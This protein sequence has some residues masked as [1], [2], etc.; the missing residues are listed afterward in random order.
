M[1]PS[2]TSWQAREEVAAADNR[3]A[4]TDSHLVA[5]NRFAATESHLVAD[6]HLVAGGSYRVAVVRPYPTLTS[7]NR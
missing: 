4:A 5:D 3:F 6:S 7:F 2:A 1:P